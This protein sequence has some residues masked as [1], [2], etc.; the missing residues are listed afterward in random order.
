MNHNVAILIPNTRWFTK[1]AWI[2]VNYASLILTRLLKDNCSLTLIDA[3]GGNMSEEKTIE[4]IKEIKPDIV[5]IPAMSVEYYK[6]N[7]KAAE[8]VKGV[9]GDIITVMGGVYV[10]T[11]TEEAVLDRNIDFAFIGYA[12]DRIEEF[13]HL[14][15]NKEYDV[16]REN[17]AGIAFLDEQGNVIINEQQLLIKDI[18]KIA[19]PDYSL[20]DMTPY[21][22][23]IE[24]REF[25]FTFNEN[26]AT[27]ITSY[28]CPYNCVFCAVRTITG[29]HIRFRDP[30]EIISEMEYLMKEYDVKAFTFMDDC[31]LFD[32]KRIEY[33]LGKIVEKSFNIKFKIFNAS[34]W[35][36]DESL[37]KLLKD[38]GCIYFAISVESGS[39]RIL[40][41]VIKKPLDKKYVPKV[42][43]WARDAGIVVSTSWIIGFPDETWNEIRETFRFAEEIDSDYAVFHI[44]TP[45]PKTDLYKS[46]VEKGFLPEDFSFRD[47]RFFGFA[48]C[49]VDSDEFTS[50][51]LKV[52]R[53]FEWDRINFKTEAKSKVIANLLNISDE[54]LLDFRKNTRLNCGVYFVPDMETN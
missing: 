1:R 48:E 37:I 40:K 44:A 22:T 4:K 25:Q 51:E 34:L 41:D 52:L 39:D 32:R 27:L 45:L 49:F 47:E 53:A 42:I 11:L 8:L 15:F 19:E 14:L 33:F 18:S 50:F 2:K 10:T 9:S 24:K 3:N 12:E 46:F 17:Y 20:T 35:H 5:L 23:R 6:Q 31:I 43:K 26:S 7:H 36:I 30:D 38:A 13:M 54:E 29:R 16:I 28:G 21:V